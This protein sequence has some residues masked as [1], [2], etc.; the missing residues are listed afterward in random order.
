MKYLTPQL[1]FRYLSPAKINHYLKIINRRADGY[2][3]LLLDFIPVDLC[4]EITFLPNSDNELKVISSN[5]IPQE[6]NIV[7]KTLRM[8]ENRFTVKFSMTVAIT[9]HIPAGGGMGGGSSNAGTVLRATEL[10]ETALDLGSDVPFFLYK[11]PGIYRHGSPTPLLKLAEFSLQHIA[12]VIPPFS[13]STA[14]AFKAVAPQVIPQTYIEPADF[15][16]R[17]MWENPAEINDFMRPAHPCYKKLQEIYALI[18][19]AGFDGVFLT[20]TGSVMYGICRNKNCFEK[21]VR[22]LGDLILA[23]PL[24]TS[25]PAVLF[26]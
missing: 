10:F 25:V 2:H 13:V 22:L 12:L 16:Y 15:N 11:I 9:K 1:Q 7:C 17:D 5:G 23:I 3:D 4:D 20:G 26:L 8:L 21:A 19:S 24:R 14:E 18:K 6:Q